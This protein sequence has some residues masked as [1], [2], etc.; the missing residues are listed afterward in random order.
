MPELTVPESTLDVEVY[1]EECGDALKATTRNQGS[2]G[3]WIEV[4]PCSKCL[5]EWYDDGVA[6]GENKG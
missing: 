3:Q 1:C 2:S 6:D 5:A 4:K